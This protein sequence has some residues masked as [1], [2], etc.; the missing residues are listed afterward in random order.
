MAENKKSG[1]GVDVENLI[2]EQTN[3]TAAAVEEAMSGALQSRTEAD[4]FFPVSLSGSESFNVALLHQK[5]S[6]EEATPIKEWSSE[7][8][9]AY[10]CKERKSGRKGNSEGE[11]YML[12]FQRNFAPRIRAISKLV[13][14]TNGNFQN[15]VEAGIVQLESTKQQHFAIVLQVVGGIRLSDLLAREGQLPEKFVNQVVVPSINNALAFLS[16]HNVTHGSLNLNSLV[17]QPEFERVV[18]LEC[19]S[20]Y[21]G[22]NQSSFY[23]PLDRAQAM[24]IGR[25][26]ADETCDYFA[27]GALLC[28]LLQG[29]G[30][31]DS[32]RENASLAERLVKSSFGVYMVQ[33][34]RFGAVKELIRGLLQDH[35]SE[36]WLTA[37]V[38]E[39]MSRKKSNA[40]NTA[41]PLK[42]SLTGYEF[43]GKP[44]LGRRALAHEIF[45]QWTPAKL[46]IKV[47]DLGRWL[48]LNVMRGDLSDEL[49][50][51]VSITRRKETVMQDSDLTKVI[52]VLDPDGPLRYNEYAICPYAL[53]QMLAFGFSK[54]K[55]EYGQ[56]VA[57]SFNHGLLTHW[58]ELQPA[59][60]DYDYYKMYWS[61]TAIAK[62]LRKPS[63]GFGI[64]RALYDMNPGLPCQS[65]MFQ[66][67]CVMSLDMLLKALD[68][69]PEELHEKQD[70]MDRHISAYIASKLNIEDEIR[71]KSVRH[72]PNFAKAPQLI[73]LAMLTL[74]QAEAKSRNLK[75]LCRWI[76]KRVA[77]L[78]ASIQGKTIRKE[79]QE[80]ISE[81]AKAGDVQ[82]LFNTITSPNFIKRDAF[83]LAE[84]MKEFERYTREINALKKQDSIER[85]AYQYGLKIAVMTAYT[86]CFGTMLALVMQL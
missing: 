52:S 23:E 83:G 67:K 15:I 32:A 84:A 13:G 17:F 6:V 41:H 47:D 1:G 48:R 82:A 27:M 74:A 70:P 43:N 28:T 73:M 12:V 85:V 65:Q 30:L 49:E 50:N 58:L 37:D 71:I 62:H 34:E 10:R 36:R 19:F 42:E 63:L 59:L 11:V 51:A 4:G 79:F 22:L 75:S 21:C 46:E 8:A 33:Q 78:V 57:D 24:P 68:E 45:L 7:F 76:L 31:F 54:G 66:Q 25:G 35:P 39:W 38:L 81:S 55:R 14:G 9:T 80:A 2:S 69:L 26:E 44:H 64:E 61:P 3:S 60:E 72:F 20:T 5:Y 53:P 86:V 56:F 77:P 29:P 18:L 40:A 16:K